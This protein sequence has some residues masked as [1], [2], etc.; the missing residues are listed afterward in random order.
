MVKVSNG[1]NNEATIFTDSSQEAATL[2]KYINKIPIQEEDVF[3]P[4]TSG[5]SLS[6][7]F[8]LSPKFGRRLVKSHGDKQFDLYLLLCKIQ[9]ETG[10]TLITID[11]E[12][13]AKQLGYTELE[14]LKKYPSQHD[15]F[16]QQI[17]HLLTRLERCGLLNYQKGKVTLKNNVSE[18]LAII[19]PFEFWDYK[20][21]DNLSMV[22][23]YMYLVCLNEA[24]RSTKYPV[25]FR[26]Q[27]DMVK[28]YGISE[29]SIT[30]AVS[31]LE[32]KGILEVTRD[33][34]TPPNFSDRKANVYKL[35]PLPQLQEAMMGLE[36]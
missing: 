31:E 6:A 30:K 15:Y 4:Y 12:S 5:V 25:W 18:K 3:S 9:Q 8:L 22:A 34:P 21:S 2:T 27:K 13:I 33:K 23:Q 36:E 32:E 11:Y 14:D 7:D 16:Y 29:R 17:Y 26:S 20:Y 35:L 1:K 24:S 28:L 19:I 10:K